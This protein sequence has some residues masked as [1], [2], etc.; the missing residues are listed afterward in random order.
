MT[1]RK[2][3]RVAVAGFGFGSLF[4]KLFKAHPDVEYVGICETSSDKIAAAKAAGFTRILEDYREALDGDAYDAVHLA[5]PVEHH[6]QPTLDVLAAGKHC[7]CAVPMGFTID[8]LRQ[9][10]K[11]E[12]KSG[13]NYMMMETNVYVKSYL[14]L[15]DLFEKGEFGR[16]Q[17]LRGIHSQAMENWPGAWLG[18]PPMWYA[19]HAVGP[20]L[21]LVKSR[22]TRV[23]CH[24]SGDMSDE[25]VKKHHNPFPVE[26]MT[27]TVENCK[28]VGEV[29]RTLFETAPM[30]GENFEVYGSR[31]SFSS[32][33]GTL[34]VMGDKLATPGGRGLPVT[35]TRPE[36]P[37]R[38]DLLPE[39]FK[40]FDMRGHG[41]A[42]MHLVHEFVRSTVEKRKS[43]INAV[44]AA[45]WCAVGIRA[46]ESAMA[47]GKLVD[48]PKFD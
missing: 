11:A 48:V 34:S 23:V 30:G 27:F 25:L 40:Q 37:M 20:L 10:V 12:R 21:A 28:A 32:I 24:G 1:N 16:V 46:H 19:T 8:E 44:T 33:Y 4:A 6:V 9:V 35:F 29:V 22:A 5:L 43:A 36:I 17:Y 38:W 15:K 39:E 7:A 2:K 41:D 3:V 47:G 18:L 14:F 13:M 31:A 42:A 45:N 26:T